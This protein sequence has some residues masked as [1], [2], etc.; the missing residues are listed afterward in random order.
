MG[1]RVERQQAVLAVGVLRAF[2]AFLQDYTA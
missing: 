1:E 2:F